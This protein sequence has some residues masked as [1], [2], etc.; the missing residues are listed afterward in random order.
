[1]GITR[2]RLIVLSASFLGVAVLALLFPLRTTTKDYGSGATG[3][4]IDTGGNPV[5]HAK[6]TLSFDQAVFD[7]IT[8]VNRAELVTD[9]FGR[10]QDYFI[11]CGKPGGAYTVTIEKPGFHTA[12]VHG[13]GMGS[14]RVVLHCQDPPPMSARRNNAG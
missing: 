12:R 10:F 5:P 3:V 9:A 7:A 8:P 11:S 14:H 13:R 4:V 1:M 2:K 6:V